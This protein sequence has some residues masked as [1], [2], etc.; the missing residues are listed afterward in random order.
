MTASVKVSQPRL[1]W[2]AAC[3]ARTVSMELRSST[4]WRAHGSRFG[5]PLMRMPRSEEISLK[6]FTS[7]GGAGTPSGTEKL[8]PMAWPGL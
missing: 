7:D 5:L 4:P 1:R 8:R 6:M 3:P 2:E